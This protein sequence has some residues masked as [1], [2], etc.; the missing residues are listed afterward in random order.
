[1]LLVC[2]KEGM[3]EIKNY[4]KERLHNL[5]DKTYKKFSS[6]LMPTIDSNTV[7]GVRVPL[8]KE[9]AIDV[10]KEY[11]KD[12]IISFMKDLP[13]QYYE[14]NNL[15]AFLIEKIDDYD[16]CLYALEDFLPYVDNWATCDSLR[17]K[18][19]KGN[20]DKLFLEIEKWLNSDK[21][22]TVRFGIEALMIHYLDKE[23]NEQY[24]NIVASIKSNEYYVN[25][26]RAWFFSEALLKQYDDTLPYFKEK[27]LDTWTHNKAIQKA[28]ESKRIS[29]KVKDELKLYKTSPGIKG[30]RCKA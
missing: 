6:S 2:Y 26:M 21:P 25:M 18:C 12:E 9:L 14:E 8:I 1:M 29:K 5:S 20:T 11:S 23:F 4:I 22:Y 13:H 16:T 15:H 19:F 3:L 10:I 27:R 28:I 17:P 24:L 7:I 30:D